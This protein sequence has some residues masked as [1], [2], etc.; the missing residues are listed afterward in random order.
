MAVQTGYDPILVVLSVAIAVFAAYTALDLGGRVRGARPGPRWSW[1]AGAALAMGGGI[2][3]M[4]F[5]GM[6]AFQMAMP[7]AYETGLTLLSLFVAVG[8]TGLAVAWVSRRHASRRDVA[9]SGPLMGV[10][11]AGMH[12]TGMAAMRIPGSLAYSPIVVSL[13][14][15]I[16]VTAATAALWLTFRENSV[17]QKL[18]AAIVMGLAVA[19]M[20]YTG[21]AAA[22][23]TLEVQAGAPHAHIAGVGLGQQNLALYVAGATFLILFLAMLASSFDQQRGQAE[24]KASEARFR[25][26]VQA[27]RGVLWTNDAEGRMRPPQPGWAALTG[28]SEAEYQGYGWADAVHPDDAGQTVVEWQRCLAERRPFVFEHRVRRHDGTWRAFAIRAVPIF[29]GAEGDG[30][31]REWVGVHTDITEQRAAEAELRESNEELQRYAYI[32]SH[33]LRAP[34]V[35]VMGF[36]GEID[37]AR[38]EVREALA[39][40]PRAE[41]I[42]RDLA[43]AVGFI[44]ASV[45]KMEGLITAILKLSREGRRTFRPE[46]LA[47][48]PLVQGLA[49]AIRHQ[50]ETAGAT[51]TVAVDLPEVTAD[52][53]AVEQVFGNL[54]DNAVKYLAPARAGRIVVTGERSGGRVLYRVADNGRGIAEADQARVFELFRRAG[55]QDRPGDGIGLAEVRATVR[56]LGG[57]IDVSSRVDEGST[58][59]VSLPSNE[60]V[61]ADEWK[62]MRG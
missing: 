24:L 37:A 59:V 32:V 47:M 31:I 19:G 36:T 33:D 46:R 55:M 25:A 34:L 17:W 38:S 41:A 60:R 35:N 28:Q 20:H 9:V 43:E 58:F 6:L 14:V 2:W 49:D 39:G 50:T 5:V 23:F 42:D 15:A 12:Y 30:R 8:V 7:V 26:A 10:G 27:V 51:V 13:S 18:A 56:A 61:R 29:D 22:T 4:H 21:M 48:T 16:A 54:L 53:L 45:A 62:S 57:R 44:Q 11:V 3:S 52:R 40:S 1:T